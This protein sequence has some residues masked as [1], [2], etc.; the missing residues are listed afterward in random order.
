MTEYQLK[1][2]FQQKYNQQNWK[3]ILSGIFSKVE[4]FSSPHNLAES[5][6]EIKFVR[7]IGN[8]SIADGNIGIFEVEIANKIKIS[9]SR[10]KLRELTAKYIDQDKI[11][12]AF[13]F[14]YAPDQNDYRFTFIAKKTNLSE[15]GE[16]LK[17]QTPPK[18]YTYVLGPNESCTTAAKRFLEL[19]L[20]VS[21]S[22]D[23]LIQA[24][25]V[26]KLTK[27]FFKKY[28]EHYELF[29]GNL[30]G[31]TY[32]KSVFNIPLHKDK[33]ENSKAEKPIR[34]FVKLL[35]GRIVFLHFLQK[36]GWLGCPS[37]LNDWKDGD[38]QFLHNLF[39][40]FKDKNHYL[41]KCLN[42][43]FFDT[44]NTKRENDIFEVT[45]TRVPYLNGGLFDNIHDEYNVIDFP[46]NLFEDLFDFFSQYNFTIDENSPDEHEVGIDPEMLGHIFENLLE[47]NKDKGAF[48]TPKEIVHY[49]CHESLIQYFKTNLSSFSEK[50]DHKEDSEI[51]VESFIHSQEL[52]PFI[53]EHAKEIDLL[54]NTVK[55]CDP[56]IGSGAF[57]MGLLKEIFQAKLLLYPY[58][59]TNKRFDPAVV[60][61]NIIQ[62]SIYG[63]DV[64]S[65]AIDIARLR[66]WLSLIVDEEE[67]T[68][69][70]NL[71]YK[72]MQGNSLLESFEG[73]DL[74]SAFLD[75]KFKVTLV[76]PQIN[77]FT[78]NVEDPQYQVN[79]TMQQKL[80]I[81]DL[82]E[83]YFK[84]TDK[85]EK[86]KLYNII[87]SQVLEHISLNL[88]LHKNQ[89]TRL[90]NETK[91]D[92]TARLSS[93]NKLSA[94][95]LYLT[96]NKLLLR[97]EQLRKEL[98]E[99]DSK[100]SKLKALEETPERPY[101]LWH[102]Y[103][104]DVF[105][106]G[107]F[108]IVIGNPPYLQL[109]K[110]SGK[111]ASLLKDSGYKTFERTG[112]IYSLFYELS[113]NVLKENG[114]Q[115]IISSSQ[116]MKASYGKSLRNL[117]LSKNPL[118]VI[119]LGP[120]VFENAVVDTNIL[121]SQNSIYKK[122]LFG[123]IFNSAEQINH[124]SQSAFQPMHYVSID[125]WAILNSIKQSINE[126]FIERGKALAKWNVNIYRGVTT[127]YNNA[128]II[129]E[130]KRNELVKSDSKYT[131]IIK[132]VLRGREIEK[133]FT[134]CENSYIVFI[135]WHFPLHDDKAIVGAST[136]SEKEF[137]TN[138]K[139]VYEYLKSH[140]KGLSERNKDETG[141]RYEWYALQRCAATYEEEFSK[142]KV[143]WKR[144]GSQL[145][146][147]YSDKEIYCLDSTCIATGEKIK[148]ITALLNSKLCQYQLFEK[149][150]K[151]G[152]GDLIISVQA[153]EPL[154]VYY[155]AEH[156]QKFIEKIVNKIIE[157]KK[158]DQD[159]ATL[160]NEID[161][162]VYKLYTLT[163]EEV[164]I[165]DPNIEQIIS[166]E[167]YVRFEIN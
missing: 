106:N 12:G 136:K 85:S 69:L 103:F 166:K 38:H 126:K 26:E 144:I 148:Y 33:K 125:N 59:K 90:L 129:D 146:F 100:Y 45:Q 13:V 67:P 61:R 145:R 44:L 165:I 54:L 11:H 156:E 40:N 137:S 167:G 93:I 20:K 95:K 158:T 128:F 34:D 151:T 99:I 83:K 47:D 53:R 78:N 162:M 5:N 111:I 51:S 131:E 80:V 116:W 57:P 46:S 81:K 62:N 98:K 119:L 71:D 157:K 29:C 1:S 147:S 72:I 164:K 132:P 41:S 108:D 28:K 153:L 27:E 113:F 84:E 66:F 139:V 110:D 76:D 65:G 160:E 24:F 120:G 48:Y 79:F 4:Y 102:F 87:E 14:Y 117:I 3:E 63:V 42:K 52:S 37:R 82:T 104:K 115:T 2:L 74:S 105:D 109:Q 16:L 30:A 133:Y 135:P 161:L 15:E 159:T 123:S 17:F 39:L 140:K 143:I 77:I 91:Q 122:Q 92:L 97:I 107:G 118:K 31:S 68:P 36:K 55:V 94:R 155:P 21:I 96:K 58:L 88:E 35:L 127:G 8:I 70:P 138:Y 134:E 150:P 101:F 152:M 22:F 6:E 9:R 154:L 64:D 142:E 141:I 10:V 56:A 163:Y 121:I 89:K 50:G 7:Q 149:S 114:I 130:S 19:S 25:S 73:I 75:E 43:L 86:Y 124:I 60:K 18:R 32:R 49:M 23:N 112:D